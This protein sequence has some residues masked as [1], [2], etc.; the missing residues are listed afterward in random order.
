VIFHEVTERNKLALFY[1]SRCT[2][3]ASPAE[4]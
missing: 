1:G 4:P 2:L 3:L